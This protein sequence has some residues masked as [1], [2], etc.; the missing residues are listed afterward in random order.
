MI[1]EFSSE[2]LVNMMR[3]DYCARYIVLDGIPT[4]HTV[5]EVRLNRRDNLEVVTKDADGVASPERKAVTI[6]DLRGVSK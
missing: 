1:F 5:V 4:D 6:R 2:L 3:T